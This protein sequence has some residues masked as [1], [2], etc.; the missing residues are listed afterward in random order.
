MIK[1]TEL[2]KGCDVIANFEG[3]LKRGE[4]ED[5]KNAEK[6]VCV[7]IG[8][9]SYWFSPEDVFS[10]EITDAEL[11]HLKFTKQ[12]NEEGNIKYMKGAFRM[13]IPKED[14]F[15]RM[16]IWYRDEQ[17]HVAEQI[18]LHVIQNHFYEMT[19]VYLNDVSF[20]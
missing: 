5:I 16:E 2:K 20:A 17:R 12:T 9:S 18:P 3:D 4:I 8:E 14:D 10:I 11:K 15:S 6:Q 1:F 13:L 7:K 19:K